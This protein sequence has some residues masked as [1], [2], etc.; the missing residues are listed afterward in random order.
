[1]G[2]LAK[3]RMVGTSAVLA[4]MLLAALGA[5]AVAAGG[6][7]R[8]LH[9]RGASFIQQ[10]QDVQW[11][12]RLGTGIEIRTLQR[13]HRS[14]CLL[15][16]PP[17]HHTVQ[18]RVCA[19]PPAGKGGGP[20][21]VYRSATATKP[22]WQ[23]ISATVKRPNSSELVATFLPSEAHI[24]Y[25]PLHWQVLSSVAPP[26]CTPTAHNPSLCADI[27]P[28]KPR[29]AK[30]H[31]PQPV[32]CVPSGPSEVFSGPSN[33]HDIALTFDDG[34]WPDPPTV[35]FLKVLEHYHVP[36][37]FFEIGDQIS[38]YDPGGALE[39]RMLADGDMIGDHTWTHPD[40]TTLSATE[41][42]SQ[43]LQTA[44]AI[45]S[46]THGFRPCIWRPPYGAVNSEVISLAR[47]L[48][49]IT[50]QWD[51]DTVDWSLPGTAV[52]YQRAVNGAHNGAIILQHF[53]GG[54]RYETLAALPQEITTLKARGYHFVSITQMLGLKL[55]YK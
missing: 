53:G 18:G 36:A 54:P 52:I 3:G 7:E 17:H 29:T 10:G 37:T 39:R 2:H 44:D 41:Q 42:R 27:F 9:I 32:G 11:S 12:V 16:E 35:D 19:A 47:S 34:P 13:Q 50:I 6:P 45:K 38:Q 43:L 31:S 30:L 46:A 33:R 49:F 15:I 14:L 40:M 21:L 48:G 8:P 22:G 23:I 24:A 20:R 1:M 51:V 4:V 55:I 26:A 28:A 25:A 5:P